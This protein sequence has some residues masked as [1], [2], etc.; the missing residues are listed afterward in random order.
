[1]TLKSV[2]SVKWTAMLLVVLLLVGGCLTC[3][4]ISKSDLVSCSKNGGKCRE[5]K[6]CP[7]NH[8]S[9]VKTICILRGK[10]CCMSKVRH[11]RAV[12]VN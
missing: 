10:I 1:M 12:D 8:Q 3:R 11:E 4:A 2:G 9:M 7:R 5:V 6:V